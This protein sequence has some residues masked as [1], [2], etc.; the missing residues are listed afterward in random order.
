MGGTLK[1]KLGVGVVGCGNISSIYLKNLTTVFDNLEVRG[2]ADL[3]PAK[4]EAQSKEFGVPRAASLE[5]LLADKSVDV[6][7][8][9]TVPLSHYAVS[10]A[11]LSA[12]KHVYGEK[13]LAVALEEGEELVALARSRGLLLGGAPDTFLG[14]GIQT[15]IKLIDDGWI[16]RPIGATAFLVGGG[17]EHWHPD[18]AFYYRVGGGPMFDMGPYYLTALVA[19]LGPAAWVSGM[20]SQAWKQRTISSAPLRGSVMDVEVATHIAGL[21]SFASG[22]TATVVTTFDAKGGSSHIPLEIWGTAGSLQVPDPNT[23]GGV[24]RYRRAGQDAWSEVPHLFGHAENSRG[25]GLSDLASAVLEG[26]APRA[27]ADL[28]LHV[29]ELMHGFHLSSASRRQYKVKHKCRR[30]EPLSS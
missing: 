19:L 26:R 21:V 27:G 12:G 16:G 24:I 5:A 11:A 14:A 6:I 13:P 22:A 8:N 20:T 4:A 18:P 7:L 17:H 10:R 15:C 3:V 28:T 30:P 25:L 29:L 9:L 23:F 2:I 1:K